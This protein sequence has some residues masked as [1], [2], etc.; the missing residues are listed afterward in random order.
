MRS[1]TRFG[2]LTGLELPA[3]AGAGRHVLFVHGWW[4]GAWVWDRFM[5]RF[6]AR[7]FACFAINLRGYHDSKHV[8]D[9][10]AI[11]IDEHVEDIRTALDALD[12]PLLVTH[13]ASGMFALKLAETRKLAAAVHLVPAP[14]AGFFSLRTTRVF[15]KYMP[16]VIRSKPFI[17]N[18]RDMIAS[19][20]NCLPPDEAETTYARMV[21]APG[22]QGVQMLTT[23]VDAS[24][25]TGP[26]LIITGSDDRLVP[27][28]V[29]HAM[30]KKFRAEIREYRHH[31]HY[32]MREPGWERIADDVID[33][34]DKAVRDGVATVPASAS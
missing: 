18:K 33:W 3:E 8:P 4:G 24:R 22:R 16:S 2:E 28:K 11:T 27:A 9:V 19:D 14:P 7:G 1:T 15:A 21:P 31:G 6:A 23:G 12:D 10:G 5:P 17:L 32:L 29:H 34:L 20:L 25:V 26:R 30:A 13:S